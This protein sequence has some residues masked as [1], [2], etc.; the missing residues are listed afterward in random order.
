[1]SVCFDILS[2]DGESQFLFNECFSMELLRLIY[3]RYTS[4]LLDSN[5]F[6]SVSMKCCS[7]IFFDQKVSL[8]MAFLSFLALSCFP[9]L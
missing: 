8:D 3:R 6:I 1:M 7:F 9:Y 5:S 2:W 4:D